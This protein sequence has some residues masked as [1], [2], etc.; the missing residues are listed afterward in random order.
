MFNRL[1][2]LNPDVEVL[3]FW[4]AVE[5]LKRA[6]DAVF[7]SDEKAST[8]WYEAKR[9]TLRHDPYGVG[10]VIDALRYLLR[11]DRGST[12]TRAIGFGSKRPRRRSWAHIRRLGSRR[13]KK[14]MHVLSELRAGPYIDISTVRAG[15]AF[16]T[17]QPR[18]TCRH[19]HMPTKLGW[20]DKCFG[21]KQTVTMGSEPVSAQAPN[22]RGKRKGSEV[23]ETTWRA[24]NEKTGIVG[25]QVQAGEQEFLLP[26]DSSVTRAALEPRFSS[27]V[28]TGLE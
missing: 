2:G 26:A 24:K 8:K 21:E 12:E 13:S 1:P 6:A 3:D 23:R 19:V 14:N 22:H 4:H 5:Y 28:E 18:P 16:R 17:P 15:I 20:I 9:H 25:N 11:K 27:W 7:W 10:N